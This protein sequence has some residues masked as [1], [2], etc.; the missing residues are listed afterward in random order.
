MPEPVGPSMRALLSILIFTF[1][2]RMW[3]QE[4]PT[5]SVNVNV[6]ALLATVHDRSG[7]IVSTLT[8]DDFVLEED[9]KPQ[10]IR[11]FSRESDLPLTVGLLVDTM[12]A[13][14]CSQAS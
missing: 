14:Q 12:P 5:L 8:P 10:K 4:A 7:R 6:V 1:A 3:T 13:S 2:A 11:Y 9:G